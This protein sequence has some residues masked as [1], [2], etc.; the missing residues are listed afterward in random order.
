[1]NEK[2]IL[3]AIIT[4]SLI[5]CSTIGYISNTSKTNTTEAKEI[6]KL[7]VQEQP[8]EL[9]PIK[10]EVTDLYF[11]MYGTKTNAMDGYTIPW[12]TFVYFNN[13]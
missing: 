8:A 5:S 1:M 9:A 7:I 10:V 2:N 4:L 11:K 6:V 3:F 12:N 13:R